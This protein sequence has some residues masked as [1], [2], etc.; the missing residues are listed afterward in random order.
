[1][2]NDINSKLKQMSEILNDKNAQ[3]AIRELMSSLKTNS[4]QESSSGEDTNSN[5][6]STA[7]LDAVNQAGDML[8]M[9]SSSSSDT[10]V[11]LLRSI[12][13][14]LSAKRKTTCSTC[15]SLLRLS[16]I[17]KAFSDQNRS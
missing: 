14:F 6:E 10:R 16:T 3:G 17:I 12:Q 7:E 2:N 8:N 1:M 9:L 13:P 11:D 4:D 15:M 5:V